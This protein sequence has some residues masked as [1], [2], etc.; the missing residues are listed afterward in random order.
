MYWTVG[1]SA[2]NVRLFDVESMNAWY[3]SYDTRTFLSGLVLQDVG[4]LILV[5]ALA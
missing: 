2:D 1:K 3:I 4:M 5:S